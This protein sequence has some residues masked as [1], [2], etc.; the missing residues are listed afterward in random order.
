M[1]AG[2][3]TQAAGDK[4]VWR[5][6]VSGYGTFDFNGTEDEAEEMRKHKAN[7]ERGHAI[8]WRKD[9]AH[10]C[11]KAAAEIASRFDQHKGVSR[12]LLKRYRAGRAAWRWDHSVAG[13]PDKVWPYDRGELLLG[14]ISLGQYSRWSDVSIERDGIDPRKP[15]HAWLSYASF[16][17]GVYQHAPS[18]WFAKPEEAKAFVEAGAL[19]TLAGAGFVLSPPTWLRQN[20]ALLAALDEAKKSLQRAMSFLETRVHGNTEAR[21]LYAQIE[22]ALSKLNEAVDA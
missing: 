20:A 12:T 17:R 13:N 22:T 14:K 3:L 19:Q 21:E 2:K 6:R 8:K 4:T 7:W 16:I 1:I 11:D 5:I 18:A 9:L 10:D 15:I